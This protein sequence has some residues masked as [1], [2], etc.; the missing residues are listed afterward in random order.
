MQAHSDFLVSEANSKLL[1]SLE[2][3]VDMSPG[4][5]EMFHVRVLP[6]QSPS[7]N[8]GGILPA[9][10]RELLSSYTPDQAVILMRTASFAGA[11]GTALE[12]RIGGVEPKPRIVGWHVPHGGC[13]VE[14]T[15]GFLLGIRTS[16]RGQRCEMPPDVRMIACD[17][18]VLL[19]WGE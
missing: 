12:G 1:Q 17:E 4:K 5:V 2:G 15:E 9:R 19:E 18:L 11:V 3:N 8:E 10:L 14:E 16:R 13:A 7:L 6:H